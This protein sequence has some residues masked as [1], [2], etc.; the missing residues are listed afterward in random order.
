MFAPAWT[1]YGG[2]R[3]RSSALV[4]LPDAGRKNGRHAGPL[5]V[6]TPVRRQPV[7]PAQVQVG[8]PEEQRAH[9][10]LLHAADPGGAEIPARQPDCA[11]RH[12]GELFFYVI[13]M[14]Y[15]YRKSSQLLLHFA[16]RRF[17]HSL[18][19]CGPG[20]GIFFLLQL[21]VRSECDAKTDTFT[22]SSARSTEK[23]IIFLPLK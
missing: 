9:H 14:Y 10:R 20:G 1:E 12:Q 17:S 6:K 3:C 7:G 11:P 23:V 15:S 2:K 8:T 16:K 19:L 18:Y 4:V 13:N 5:N 22:T 21:N